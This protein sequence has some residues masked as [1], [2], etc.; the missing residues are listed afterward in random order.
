[1]EDSEINFDDLAKLSK[2][3][4]GKRS[5]EY[6]AKRLGIDVRTVDKYRK[7][8]RKLRKS[9]PRQEKKEDLYDT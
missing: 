6:Y 2:L 9:S 7:H 1:M 3:L 8:I 4:S 5:K